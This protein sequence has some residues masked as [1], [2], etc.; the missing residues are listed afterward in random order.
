VEIQ[1]AA[2]R[3]AALTRQ[4]LSFSRPQLAKPKLVNLNTIVT[5]LSKILERVIGEDIRLVIRLAPDLP[6]I[7]ADPVQM[8]QIVMNLAV[9]AR[10]AMPDGGTLRIE[11][12][13]VNLPEKEARERRT[14]PGPYVSLIA[15]DSGMGMD[16]ATKARLFEAFFTTKEKG[17]GTGLGLSIVSGIVKHSG[18]YITVESAPGAGAEFAVF[19][20]VSTEEEAA[21]QTGPGIKASIGGGETILVVEDEATVRHLV[22]DSLRKRG[23]QV[24]EA[25]TPSA[26]LR[27]AGEAGKRIDLLISDVLMPEMRGP[28]LV[29]AI[30]NLRPGIPVLYMSGYSD[31]SFLDPSVLADASYIQKPFQPDE[32]ARTIA[33][34]LKKSN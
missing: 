31:S 34:I 23:Y 16:T 33:D 1:R 12:G 28:E 11:T 4:L 8:D 29:R 17:K 9:N 19:L 15:R 3:A 24:I 13:T 20:P 14:A 26:A 25:A 27:V 18:G 21:E 30:R 6:N 32:L 2:D 22:R 5:E 7:L 10:D